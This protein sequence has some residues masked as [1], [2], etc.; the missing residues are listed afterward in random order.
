MACGLAPVGQFP[1]MEGRGQFPFGFN[2]FGLFFWFGRWRASDIYLQPLLVTKRHPAPREPFGAR[3]NPP[4][5][6]VNPMKTAENS[7]VRRRL[8]GR[9]AFISSLLL[10]ASAFAPAASAFSVSYDTLQFKLFGL[11]HDERNPLC[12]D[13]YMIDQIGFGPKNYCTIAVTVPS[14]GTYNLN[15]QGETEYPRG[16][17]CWVGKVNGS[18]GASGNGTVYTGSSFKIPVEYSIGTIVLPAGT[19]TLVWG[20]AQTS[21]QT[22]RCPYISQVTVSQ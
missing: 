20:N 22:D 11:A 2:L 10:I 14:A 17:Y 19:S 1:A 12:P 15:F 7:S 4:T 21:G 8:F 18:P 6:V 5:T 9:F 3:R 13:G 16:L